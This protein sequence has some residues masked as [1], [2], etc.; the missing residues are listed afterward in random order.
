VLKDKFVAPN[1]YISQEEKSQINNL[2]SHLKSLEKEKQTKSKKSRRK[3]MIKIRNQ[4][5]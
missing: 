5:T 4:L 2:S 1:A 3:E